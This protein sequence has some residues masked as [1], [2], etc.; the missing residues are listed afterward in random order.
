MWLADIVKNFFISRITE[1]FAGDVWDYKFI[2]I[3]AWLH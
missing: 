2:N 3:S 1:E